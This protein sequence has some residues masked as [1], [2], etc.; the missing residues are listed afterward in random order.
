MC[1]PV[2]RSHRHR[3][4]PRLGA[5]VSLAAATRITATSSSLS[6]AA[7]AWRAT[8]TSSAHHGQPAACH[9]HDDTCAGSQR[10][11][12]SGQHTCAS[13]SRQ[14]VHT[15]AWAVLHGPS[16]YGSNGVQPL[17]RRALSEFTRFFRL[18]YINMLYMYRA[19]H[20]VWAKAQYVLSGGCTA[21]RSTWGRM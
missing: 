14:T 16:W 17:Y 3:S 5:P 4:S 13:C 10:T 12:R 9:R 6:A 8:A 21:L 18:L 19:L 20:T 15:C 7:P 1:C 2:G 11:A